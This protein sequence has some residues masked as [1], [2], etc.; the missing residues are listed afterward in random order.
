[1]CRP[2]RNA[3][4]DVRHSG[5]ENLIQGNLPR[6]GNGELRE[7]R[8]FAADRQGYRHN[9]FTLARGCLLPEQRCL[10]PFLLCYPSRHV[11]QDLIGEKAEWKESSV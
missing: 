9:L 10:E 3:G 5:S 11:G 6:G 1:M 7:R 4:P 8:L 2:G